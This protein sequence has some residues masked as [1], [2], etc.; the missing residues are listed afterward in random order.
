MH[1]DSHLNS[2]QNINNIF[3]NKITYRNF[4][5]DDSNQIYKVVKPDII[6]NYITNKPDNEI[7]TKCLDV[8]D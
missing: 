8:F 5:L 7:G 1:V 4:K 6:E 2:K 3:S